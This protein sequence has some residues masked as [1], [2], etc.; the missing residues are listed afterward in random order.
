MLLLRRIYHVPELLQLLATFGIV[1]IVQDLVIKVW[2][3]L[4]ILGPR[5][6]GLRHAVPIFGRMFP[7]YEMFLD[8]RRARWCS[9]CCTC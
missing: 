8:R 5:A 7:A 4:E 1:L 3:P 6:P 2:G 9:A